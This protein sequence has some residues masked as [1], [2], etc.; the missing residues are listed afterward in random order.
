MMQGK[1]FCERCM[2]IGHGSTEEDDYL[3][4][5]AKD[6]LD[7]SI[8]QRKRIFDQGFEWHTKF[9]QAIRKGGLWGQKESH[10]EK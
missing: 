7:G 6:I 8:P 3:E 9:Y 5:S 1:T 4:Q 10:M 2:D